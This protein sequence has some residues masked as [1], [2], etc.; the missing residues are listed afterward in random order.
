[1]AST[2]SQKNKFYQV[3]SIVDKKNNI[4]LY[5]GST[6][7]RLQDR[8]YL[9]LW[10]YASTHFK[11]Y[12]LNNNIDHNNLQIKLI[13]ICENKAEMLQSE[14]EFIQNIKPL[15]NIIHNNIH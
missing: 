7:L 4:I 13:K 2:I 15:C 1:M 14:K 12:I 3:Y 6:T 10:D 11:S 9:H 5:V 8:L